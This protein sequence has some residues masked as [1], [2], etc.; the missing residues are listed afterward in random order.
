MID[1]HT[2]AEFFAGIGCA[3]VGFGASWRCQFAN[4]I[5]AGKALIYWRN[6][7]DD[8]FRLCDVRH[9][10]ADDVPTVDLAMASPP[11]TD[12]S[13]AGAR[14]GIYAE[15]SGVVWPFIGILRELRDQ[16][17]APKL[18]VVEN[19]RGMVN[20]RDGRDVIAVVE[21]LSG[22]SYA[23]GAVLI[24]AAWFVPQSRPR[25]FLIAVRGDLVIPDALRGDRPTPWCSTDAL[26]KALD[27]R[28]TWWPALPLP[29]ASPT[30]LETC[31]D[32][33]ATGW[34]PMAPS[35]FGKP[36]RHAIERLNGD[37]R[38]GTVFRRTRNEG[39]V[40]ELR[41]DG[42][43]GALRVASGGSSRQS[44]ALIEGGQVAR[45]LFTP[46]ECARIMGLPDGFWLPP[47]NDGLTA[48]GDGIS[49]PVVRHLAEHLF[50]P[51]LATD[52]R[53]PIME[54]LGAT[55]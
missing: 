25:V 30:A 29:T 18:A 40:W 21:A 15:R 51:I 39:P 52:S 23:V 24:D 8:H 31:F 50:E 28:V 32:A 11:C 34:I 49:P 53:V 7:G 19:V 10:R 36:S 33:K 1:P 5:D 47:G 46:K 48:V 43:A 17:R 41:L 44:W 2:F 45:R 22:A 26:V 9:N 38:L 27:G 6:H 12:L 54:D 3:R 37:R 55:P 13:E 35:D 42:R 20:G 14:A 16:H 4:D